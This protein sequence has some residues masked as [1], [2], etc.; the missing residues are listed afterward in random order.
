MRSMYGDYIK[1]RLGDDIIETEEGFVTWRIINNGKSVYGPDVY[2]KPEF[3]RKGAAKRLVDAI[4][5]KGI[6][7]GC[8]EVLGTVALPMSTPTKSIAFLISYGFEL[9][10]ASQELLIF[11]KDIG[12]NRLKEGSSNPKE[13]V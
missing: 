8:V 10:S 13:Q 5:Q 1:E 4:V 2:V 11:R 6:E 9:Q 3:R 12:T 7:R